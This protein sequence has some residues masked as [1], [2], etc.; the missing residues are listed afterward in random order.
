MKLRIISKKDGFRRAG[1]AHRGTRVYPAEFFSEEQIRTLLAEPMLVVEFLEEHS[2]TGNAEAE[3]GQ[4]DAPEPQ[5]TMPKTP[6][7]KTAGKPSGKKGG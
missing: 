1:M 7:E 2:A 3:H 6:E 5:E 4:P